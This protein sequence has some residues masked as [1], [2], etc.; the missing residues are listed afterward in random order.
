MDLLMMTTTKIQTFSTTR[1]KNE[2]KSCDKFGVDMCDCYCSFE[3]RS[4][5]VMQSYIKLKQ[6]HALHLTE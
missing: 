1:Y 5:L 2:L 4:K 6:Q 3:V